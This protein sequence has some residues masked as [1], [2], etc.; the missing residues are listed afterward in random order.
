MSDLFAQRAHIFIRILSANQGPYARQL[1][2]NAEQQQQQ[3]KRS[4]TEQTWQERCV[5]VCE[6]EHVYAWFEYIR[7]TA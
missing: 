4:V 2:T 6:Y 1:K 7:Q 5:S 3:Q